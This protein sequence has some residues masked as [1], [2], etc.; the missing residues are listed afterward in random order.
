MHQINFLD[1]PAAAPP[2]ARASDPTT[3]HDS[4]AQLDAKGLRDEYTAAALRMVR[5]AGPEG[6][7]G[8]EMP[9][10]LR[11]RLTELEESNLVRRGESRP[12]KTTGFS[13]TT[14]WPAKAKA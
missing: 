11:K 3:S 9:D 7:C 4:A 10:N 6:I 2:I 5:E 1:E 8:S 13:N 14:W 12:S